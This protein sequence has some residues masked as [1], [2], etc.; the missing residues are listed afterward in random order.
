MLDAD[1]EVDLIAVRRSVE[2]MALWP[3]PSFAVT[4]CGVWRRGKHSFSQPPE[5][6]DPAQHTERLTRQI[7]D[8]SRGMLCHD[9][10]K[11]DTGAPLWPSYNDTSTNWVAL[12][13]MNQLDIDPLF[14]GVYG[15]N[16]VPMAYHQGAG[17]RHVATSK[18]VPGPSR[19]D[20]YEDVAFKL[21]DMVLDVM[22]QPNGTEQLVHL[23]LYPHSS[24]Y[25]PTSASRS[26]TFNSSLGYNN[27]AAFARTL[28]DTCMQLRSKL[29]KVADEMLFCVG[30]SEGLCTP[31]L[32]LDLV[33]IPKTGGTAIETW[34]R[35]QSPSIRWGRF[36]DLWP[37]GSCYWGCRPTWQPCSAWHL[38]PAIF[39]S[40]GYPAYRDASSNMCVVRNPFDRAASQVAWLLRNKALEDPTVCQP[41]EL[42]EHVRTMLGEMRASLASVTAAFPNLATSDMLMSTMGHDSMCFANESN[43]ECQNRVA[44][45]AFREDCHWLPQWMYVEGECEH[46]MRTETL[47]DDFRSLLWRVAGMEADLPTYNARNVSACPIDASMFD[48]DTEALLREVY[49]KDFSLYGYESAISRPSKEDSASSPTAESNYPFPSSP[50][51][52]LMPDEISTHF[53]RTTAGSDN[54]KLKAASQCEAA[55]QGALDVQL[56]LPPSFQHSNTLRPNQDFTFV[57]VGKTCGTTVAKWINEDLAA[58]EEP[59]LQLSHTP[60]HA[61]PM[62]R[63]QI[64]EASH[65]LV[66]LR[67][68][69]DRFV[70]AFNTYAC[71]VGQRAALGG[72]RLGGERTDGWDRGMCKR[73]P[74]WEDDDG[75]GAF[76]KLTTRLTHTRNMTEA[77][78][79]CFPTV[80]H[81]AGQLDKKT[82]CGTQARSFMTFYERDAADENRRVFIEKIWERQRELGQLS[83]GEPE[84]TLFGQHNGS[85]NLESQNLAG[86][87][88]SGEGSGDRV[89]GLPLALQPPFISHLLM[90]T[91]FYLGGLLD[92]IKRTHK[93][94]YVVET[95]DCKNDIW[96]IPGWIGRKSEREL[97]PVSSVHAGD[98]PHH[99]DTL[100]PRGRLLLAK[101]LAPEYFANDVL[102]RLSV[103]KHGNEKPRL[104]SNAR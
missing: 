29:L 88:R 51:A 87:D 52:E 94:V 6:E 91:C 12:D 38:P 18:V 27:T 97:P 69:V 99:N 92:Y 35:E 23:L 39:R 100:T 14:Y 36:R 26:S 45:P 16:G 55:W 84:G 2:G 19:V 86:P 68:P 37:Q 60:V 70:S 57:H 101:A 32:A 77:F 95:E 10:Y 17:S 20:G 47:A 82:P 54:S 79:K 58:T 73:A 90:G 9:H 96:G 72:S 78:F 74:V 53:F 33:H 31:Q 64:V 15:L 103:N 59:G 43:K 80:A 56:E 50:A 40:K 89:D 34:G 30:R 3:H 76:A 13:R 66:T 48:A 25:F 81:F 98:M 67:D 65:I 71:K 104:R 22:G 11:L 41:A 44:Q 24:P 21:D 4:T 75:S 85:R 42:N 63:R 28:V 7:F 102:R 8:H 49:A 93:S 61:H 83:E 1:D 46:V 5:E 62:F